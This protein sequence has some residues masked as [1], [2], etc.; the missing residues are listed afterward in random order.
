MA[1]WDGENVDVLMYDGRGGAIIRMANGTRKNVPASELTDSVKEA[2]KEKAKEEKDD[3][4][5]V[6]LT[7]FTAGEVDT[8]EEES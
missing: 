6:G 3:P 4:D 2:V 1:N 8:P 7:S 5:A